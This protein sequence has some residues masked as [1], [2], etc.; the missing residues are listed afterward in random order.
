MDILITVYYDVGANIKKGEKLQA[1]LNE[2][3]VKAGLVGNEFNCNHV[4]SHSYFSETYR[5]TKRKANNF[6][7]KARLMKGVD[8]VDVV[9]K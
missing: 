9:I 1:E 5:T 8:N 7:T 4:L 2:A 3:A 6:A